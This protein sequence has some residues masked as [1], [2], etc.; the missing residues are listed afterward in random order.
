MS[1]WAERCSGLL[2]YDFCP[3]ANRWVYWIKQP[4]AALG[5]AAVSALACAVFVQPLAWVPS[6]AVMLVVALGYLWPSVAM[7]GLSAEVSFRQRRVTEGETARAVLRVVN[8][9]PWPVWGVSLEEGFADSRT[10]ALARVAGWSTN[11]FLW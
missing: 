4:V 1:T 3:W 9:W 2:T 10:V 7:R 11:E 6:V 8:H 5:L